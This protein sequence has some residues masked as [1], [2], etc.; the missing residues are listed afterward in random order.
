M[1]R[2]Q[3]AFIE[4]RPGC[5]VEVQNDSLLTVIAYI[6]ADLTFEVILEWRDMYAS[7]MVGRTM[8][9]GRPPGHLV[10]FGLRVRYHLSDLLPT[11][12]EAS[13]SGT[14]PVTKRQRTRRTTQAA[15]SNTNSAELL[16]R[17]AEPIAALAAALAESFDGVCAKARR[18]FAESEEHRTL[19]PPPVPPHACPGLVGLLEDFDSLIQYNPVLREIQHWRSPTKSITLTKCPACGKDL[20]RSLRSDLHGAMT[21]VPPDAVGVR[22]LPDEMH[23]DEWWRR[24]GL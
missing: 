10:H 24:R 7:A 3:F 12:A 9:G 13:R 23:N 4:Q 16:D 18:G 6:L 15:A 19:N 21:E 14:A 2:E 11:E 20:P 22:R 5:R 1:V 8:G 17:M